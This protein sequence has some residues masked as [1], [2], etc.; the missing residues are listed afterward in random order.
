MVRIRKCLRLAVL[1]SS[2]TG[3][4][5]NFCSAQ[6]SNWHHWRGP[7]VSG[8]ISTGKPPIKWSDDSHIKWKVDVPGTGS[9]SPIV[10]DNQI[11]VLSALKTERVKEGGDN[12]P[13]PAENQAAERQDGRRGGRRGG[14]SPTNYYQFLVLSYDRQTGKELWRQAVAEAVPHEAGHNTNTFASSSPVTDGKVIIASFGSRGVYCL[15][16]KGKVQW[17]KQFG[18]MRTAAGFGEG[19][20]AT[21]AGDKVIVPWDHEGESFIVALKV[22]DGTELWRTPRKEGTTWG[23]P[24]IVN[25]NGRTQ[26]IVNGRSVRSYDAADGKQIWECGGMTSNPIPTPIL[27]G[28]NVIAATGF[29]G[30]SI[31]SIPLDSKG[32]VT[33]KTTWSNGDAA[34][35][36]PT[37]T[38][39]DGKLYLN[40]TNGGIVSVLDA[41]TG[42]VLVSQ[43][44]LDD[45]PIMYSS[46][47]AA[48]GHIYFTSRD[49]KTVVIKNTQPI[50]VVATNSL[51]DTI[52]SSFA[53]VGDN[54]FVRGLTQ[55][56]CLE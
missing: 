47:V 33:G 12:P 3:A 41:Q 17:S 34:P 45:I 35:Y 23:T 49:G 51:D 18:T 10:H 46:P 4:L 5:T 50:E 8:S 14:A 29:R 6:E 16:M 32:D 21:L 52:D 22:T 24:L 28:E 53:I 48:G 54:I 7:N 36:V 56:Y 31:V 37:P 11:I 43:Q 20:S 55:L 38:L 30:N 25:H 44:R 15:D 1:T 27:F 39:Y 26:V 2:L 19:A 42:K 13:P 40:K 9:S